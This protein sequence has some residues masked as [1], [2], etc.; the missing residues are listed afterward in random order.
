M[1]LEGLSSPFSP[2]VFKVFYASCLQRSLHLSEEKTSKGP[3]VGEGEGE[4]EEK[5]W[6]CLCAWEGCRHP[7]TR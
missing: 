3:R 6:E 2:Q 7:L 1:M 5:E 4:G